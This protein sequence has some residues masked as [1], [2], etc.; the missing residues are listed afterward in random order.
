[1]TIR[2]SK[3]AKYAKKPPRMTFRMNRKPAT[4]CVATI[5]L[6]DVDP[7]DFE[8]ALFST[9]AIVGLSVWGLESL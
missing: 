1:M 3:Q 9:S 6:M 5:A 8:P 7:P 2:A 4:C